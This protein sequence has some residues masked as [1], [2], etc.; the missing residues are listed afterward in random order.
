VSDK[1][2]LRLNLPRFLFGGKQRHIYLRL[3]DTPENRKLAEA[4]AMQIESDIKY[5]RFD[6]SLDRYRPIQSSAPKNEPKIRTVARV[7]NEWVESRSPYVAPGTEGNYQK[8]IRLLAR[9]P[10][11]ELPVKAWGKR[12]IA[13]F[14]D[15]LREN[16]SRSLA[17]KLLQHLNTACDWAESRGEISVNP[18]PGTAGQFKRQTAIPK[19]QKDIDPFSTSERD[20]II[21]R[22]GGLY[23]EYSAF[24]QFL[25][26]TGCRPSEAIALD[27][28]QVDGRAI[29]FL[30]GVVED[31]RG[32]S[33]RKDGLKT[34]KRRTFPI[35]PQLQKTLD[36]ASEGGGRVGL[37]FPNPSGRGYIERSNF[38]KAWKAVLNDLGI[39]YRK[40]YQTRHT[41]I[42]LCLEKNV[43]VATI[44]KWVGNSPNTIFKYY[45]GP[46]LATKVPEL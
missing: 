22:F 26:F 32:R 13:Q 12:E 23:P 45:A 39:R 36:L 16:S 42:T 2:A 40:P 33:R 11:G 31:G 9:S 15:W 35:N 4:K 28:E 29:A 19:G 44:A 41:F 7:L 24:V 34:Q 1:G 8:S 20:R 18:W 21:Q 30:A 38:R 17:I 3:P 43:P 10:F 37:V 5:E 6:Y 14:M 25:F 27:W 46:G